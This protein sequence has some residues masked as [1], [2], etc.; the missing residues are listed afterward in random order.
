MWAFQYIGRSDRDSA[1][2]GRAGGGAT[3]A[4]LTFLEVF[5]VE[6]SGFKTI[7]FLV[8]SISESTSP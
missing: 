7:C 2:R 1:I 6:R 4:S 5:F 8:C 3:A